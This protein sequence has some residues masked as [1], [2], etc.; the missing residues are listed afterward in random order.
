MRGTA[1]HVKKS[2]SPLVKEYIPQLPY[3]S[4]LKS[5]YTSEQF[6]MFM[7]LLKQVH[8]NMLFVKAL[9]QMLKYAKFLKDLLTNKKI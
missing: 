3:F 5:D 1:P 8:I 2:V 9:S 7:D 6:K 4:G